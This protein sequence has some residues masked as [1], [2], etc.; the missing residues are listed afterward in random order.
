MTATPRLGG[1]REGSA[2][3]SG[4]VPCWSVLSRGLFLASPIAEGKCIFSQDDCDRQAPHAEGAHVRESVVYET[5]WGQAAPGQGLK[6]MRALFI[7]FVSSTRGRDV[8]GAL[9]CVTSGPSGAPSLM[10]TASP[11]LRA[12]SKVGFDTCFA[13]RFP[14]LCLVPKEPLVSGSQAEDLRG[15]ASCGKLW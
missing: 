11:V 2:V 10:S 4:T 15:S 1:G 12:A 9:W 3:P 6:E 8:M 14:P 7:L 5:R 13:Q